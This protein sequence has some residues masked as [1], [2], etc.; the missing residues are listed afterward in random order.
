MSKMDFV[1]ENS[2]FGVILR[3]PN[4]SAHVFVFVVSGVPRSV[5]YNPSLRQ[6]IRD[7]TTPVTVQEYS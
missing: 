1:A 7:E 6:R 2:P 5:Q 3:C 4:P